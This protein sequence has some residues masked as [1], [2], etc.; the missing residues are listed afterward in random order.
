MSSVRQGEQVE[1]TVFFGREEDTPEAKARWFQSLT[2]EERMDVL[3]WFTD[4]I[5]SVNPSIAQ[6]HVEPVAGRV[7]V[8]NAATA[9]IPAKTEAGTG[10]KE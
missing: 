7:L 4:L 2:L 3:C 10:G 8:L 1:P 5:V 6:K 9:V